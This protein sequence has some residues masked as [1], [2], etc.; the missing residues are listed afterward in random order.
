MIR[1]ESYQNFNDNITEVFDNNRKMAIITDHSDDRPSHVSILDIEVSRELAE[2]LENYRYNLYLNAS[3]ISGLTIINDQI[4]Y[5][6][7]NNGYTELIE[8]AKII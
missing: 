8:V 2:F 5:T 4:V 3:D 1:T 6:Y 7:N